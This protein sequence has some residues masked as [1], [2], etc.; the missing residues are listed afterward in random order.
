MGLTEGLASRRFRFWDQ[1][2]RSRSLADWESRELEK[3]YRQMCRDQVR[4]QAAPPP[5]KR[6]KC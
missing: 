4:A 6:G 2:S 3:S 1:E 5:R